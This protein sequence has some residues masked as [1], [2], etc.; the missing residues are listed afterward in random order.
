MKKVTLILLFVVGIFSCDKDDDN[1]QILA[2][3]Y[4]EKSPVENRTKMIFTENRLIINK[5][6]GST[7]DEFR[8]E[9]TEDKITL[10]PILNPELQNVLEIRIID[11]S[12]F[13]VENLYANIPENPKVYILFKKE[14]N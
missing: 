12:S 11:N 1:N 6:N 14:N 8:F 4:V 13:E 2:G 10:T 5:S 7:I 3:I 9:I